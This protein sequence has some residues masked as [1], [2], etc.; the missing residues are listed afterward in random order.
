MAERDGAAVDVELVLVQR[1]QGCIQ[2]ELLLAVGGVL[3][4]GDAAEHLRG[5]GFV[6]FP[7][8][9]VV[10][11][12][13]MTLEYRRC[14][15]H[16]T[17]AHLRRV[18]SRPLR[19]EDAADGAQAVLLY[20]LFRGEDQPGSAVGDLGRIPRRDVAVFAI[21]KRLELRQVFHAGVAAHAVV[22]RV[23]PAFGVV[24]RHDFLQTALILRA[25]HA[26]VAAHRVRVHCGAR[27]TEALCEVL[28]GLAHEQAD[29]GI[30]QPLHDADH[31]R[32]IAELQFGEHGRF[33]AEGPRGVETGEPQHHRIGQ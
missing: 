4:R 28:C 10:E 7:G 22:R 3:P 25:R 16:R 9:Q 23:Q 18:Q 13:A 11:T 21:E 31:R 8:I 27:D 32:E 19:I 15:M 2:A 12:Q 20:R 6:D 26:L 24:D 5:E 33:L 14:R 30:G 1:A 17:Q 29:V